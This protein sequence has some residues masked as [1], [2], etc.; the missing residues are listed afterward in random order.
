MDVEKCFQGAIEV[1]QGYVTY[2][3]GDVR[4][5]DVWMVFD[6]RERLSKWIWQQNK[7]EFKSESVIETIWNQ[8]MG[9]PWIVK[10]QEKAKECVDEEEM[11]CVIQLLYL[12]DKSN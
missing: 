10:M 11:W 6:R 3:E 2:D 8:K 4:V 9:R 5:L 7:V 12:S 1:L